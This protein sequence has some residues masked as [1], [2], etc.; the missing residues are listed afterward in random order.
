MGE[1][2]LSYFSALVYSA[3]ECDSDRYRGGGPGTPL[4]PV[5]MVSSC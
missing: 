5:D 1:I 3:L 4:P 2:G